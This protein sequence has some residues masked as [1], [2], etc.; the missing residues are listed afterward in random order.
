MNNVIR[1]YILNSTIYI[2]AKDNFCLKIKP[3]FCGVFCMVT[4]FSVM[5]LIFYRKKMVLK[6]HEFPLLLC[7][8]NITN[9]TKMN[10]STVKKVTK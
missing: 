6:D 8:S 2:L 3:Q 4:V 7:V 9:D 1:N 10:E 5:F